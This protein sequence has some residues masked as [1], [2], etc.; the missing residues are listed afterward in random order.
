MPMYLTNV[1]DYVHVFKTN[2]DGTPLTYH[3]D[4]VS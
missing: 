2:K 3:Y 1:V 4:D